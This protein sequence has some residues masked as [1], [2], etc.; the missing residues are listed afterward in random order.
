MT[1]IE[2]HTPIQC[3]YCNVSTRLAHWRPFSADRM[4]CP[5]CAKLMPIRQSLNHVRAMHGLYDLRLYAEDLAAR[6]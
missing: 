2:D 6:S 5:F 4:Q 1:D 3:A